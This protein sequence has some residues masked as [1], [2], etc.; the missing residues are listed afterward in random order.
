ME[1]RDVLPMNQLSD[2]VFEALHGPQPTSS[3]YRDLRERQEALVRW[4]QLREEFQGATNPITLHATLKAD[5]ETATF[6]APTVATINEFLKV[7]FGDLNNVTWV[8]R[9]TKS[10][11]ILYYV[12]ITSISVAGGGDSNR[13]KELLPLRIPMNASLK[14]PHGI[15]E[16]LALA[17]IVSLIEEGYPV[18]GYVSHKI[19]GELRTKNEELLKEIEL[20]HPSAL[21]ALDRVRFLGS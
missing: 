6:G 19:P 16:T 15:D 2:P 20:A 10:G 4:R 8:K 13:H 11:E 9:I 17:T 18:L 12:Y 5:P 7:F 1:I 14:N 3:V 21:E